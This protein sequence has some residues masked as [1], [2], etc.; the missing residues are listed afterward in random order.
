M[1]SMTCT[2][3]FKILKKILLFVNLVLTTLLCTV[4]TLAWLCANRSF[5]Y[6]SMSIVI[7]QT[8]EVHPSETRFEVEYIGSLSSISEIILELKLIKVIKSMFFVLLRV[9]LLV[10]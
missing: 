10:V 7:S 3:Y 9:K 1:E 5:L 2:R 4:N 6:L 8:F